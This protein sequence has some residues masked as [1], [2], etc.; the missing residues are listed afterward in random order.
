MVGLE[1]SLCTSSYRFVSTM[2]SCK[3]I[4]FSFW[5]II[6]N[7]TFV[8]VCNFCLKLCCE[9][10]TFKVFATTNASNLLHYYKEITHFVCSLLYCCVKHQINRPSVHSIVVSDNYNIMYLQC[11]HTCSNWQLFK[12][13]LLLLSAYFAPQINIGAAKSMHK[14]KLILFFKHRH[15]THTY[16]HT[17]MQT[18][19]HTH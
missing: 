1:K 7:T 5:H 2:S 17:H 9:L 18:H 11:S 6:I 12:H 8:S 13:M 19:I 10:S 14:Y 3:V 15:C 16:T 4:L